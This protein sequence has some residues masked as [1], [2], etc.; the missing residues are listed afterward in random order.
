MVIRINVAAGFCKQDTVVCH[1]RVDLCDWRGV[2]ALTPFADFYCCLC[3]MSETR[4]VC[5]FA[6]MPATSS[7]ARNRF[8]RMLYVAGLL[9]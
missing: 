9:V 7:V 3:L 5:W 4:F 8:A 2:V 1:V 6:E